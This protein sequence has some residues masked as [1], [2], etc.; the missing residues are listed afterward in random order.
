VV[1]VARTVVVLSASAILGSFF[2]SWLAGPPDEPVARNWR[3]RLRHAGRLLALLL[4]GAIAV[5]LLRRGGGIDRAG[6]ALP[7]HVAATGLWI[8]L[9]LPLTLLRPAA[10]RRTAV[11]RSFAGRT[12]RRAAAL[13]LAPL[14][15]SAASGLALVWTVPGGL[16]A[17]VAT[18]YGRLLLAQS[19]LLVLAVLLLARAALSLR[20]ARG[21]GMAP[22]AIRSTF[23][24][25]VLATGIG[26]VEVLVVAAVLGLPHDVPEPLVWPLPYRLAPSVTWSF[27]GVPGQVIVGAEVLTA[28]LLALIAARRIRGWRPLL[29]AAGVVLSGLGVYKAVAP[30]TLEAYPT[31]YAEP[32]VAATPGSIRRGHDVFVTHCAV[33]HGASGRGDG[34]AAAGLVQ[35]P[36][37][38]TESHIADHMPGDLYWWVTHGLGLAMPA[39]GDQLSVEDRWNVVNFVRTLASQPSPPAPRRAG[40]SGT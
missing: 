6:L 30:L 27:P 15:V 23:R 40:G 8:G 29:V 5:L 12:A 4:M 34:P 36:A 3:R 26:A 11:A 13:A 22:S 7:A 38:L 31:T 19:I 18:R 35:R 1:L 16:P 14:G 9:L 10:S 21:E 24:A 37:D 17:L 2:V 28:G 33:C 39:F 20:R 25:V 32:V